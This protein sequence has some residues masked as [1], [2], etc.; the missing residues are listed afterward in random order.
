[1]I[2]A[3]LSQFWVQRLGWMLLHFLWQGTAIV[4]VYAVLR[5]FLRRAHGRYRLAC[6]ALATMV[7]APP[8]T[9]FLIAGGQGRTGRALWTISAVEGQRLLPAV[10]GIWL[11]GVLFFSIRLFG[12]WRFTTRLRSTA[13][14]VPAEWQKALAE[15]AVRL[16]GALPT[17]RLLVS[18][19]VDVPT[20]IGWLRPVI[21]L[22]VEFLTGMPAEHISALL[23]HEMA[24]ICRR[25]YL[26]SVLQSIAEAV[27]FYHPAV[28]WI[29][30]QIRAERELCCDDLA[31]ASGAEVL[32]YARALA[33]LES[34]QPSRLKPALA[35]SDGSLVNRIR[36]LIEPEQ[37]LENNLPGVAAAWAMT[38]LWLIGVGTV[39]VHAA[40]TPVIAPTV[41]SATSLIPLPVSR[42]SPFGL[43]MPVPARNVLLF[44]PI[45]SAQV[46]QP[47]APANNL[48]VDK[49][50][51]EWTDWVNSDVPYIITD[52]E[53]IAFKALNTNEERAV[54]V[55]QFW[56]RRDPTPDT[57]ENEYKEEHYRRIQYANDHFASSIPGWKTDRGRIYIEF[58]PPDEIEAHPF[59]HDWRYRHIEGIGDNINIH[60]IDPAMSGEYHMIPIFPAGPDGYADPDGVN[61]FAKLQASPATEFRDLDGVATR[62]TYNILPMR[63]R[64]DYVRV[65]GASTMANITVQFENRDL[66]FPGGDRSKARVN[67]F[68]RVSTMARRPVTTFEKPIEIDMPSGQIA[69]LARQKTTYQQPVPLAPGRYRLNIAVKN[70]GSGSMNNYEVALD[71]PR[72]DVDKLAASSLILADTIER[73]PLKNISDDAMFAIGDIKVRPRVGERFT[74]EEKLG[75]YL[76]IYNFRT[77]ENSHE[78]SGSIQYEIDRAGTNEKVMNF[79]EDIA[80][81]PH[82][83]ASQV[84][85]EKLLPL[86]TFQPGEY[87]LKVTATDKI[88]N[89]TVRRTGNFTVSL[90]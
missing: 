2:A 52:A 73:L 31:I 84:T 81:V 80:G 75:V 18:S 6:I 14:P 53:R 67:L 39:A 68:G 33:T 69:T 7:I 17:V 78:P 45:L 1:V 29:S 46:V 60:F 25:D 32:T 56:L 8:L 13:H 44:D 86:T 90:Q 65:T 58:G 43:T 30:Q 74:S 10:V 20:V 21:L 26:V 62:I 59:K 47:L 24:H 27:L 76:Q 41:V 87:A 38:L 51:P 64:V 34:R 11:V 61:Q 48:P 72:F 16:G 36:R 54:F 23:A 57:I 28:W 37:H 89:Q 88:G 79:S 71:V 35:A 82:A 12:G 19:L 4:T 22:P 3:F 9:F 83:S 63:V 15:I 77:D 42:P 5:S 85:I 66:Q 49:L 40:Q 55:E 70:V 50:Q